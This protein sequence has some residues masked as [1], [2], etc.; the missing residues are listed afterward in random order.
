MRQGTP[1]LPRPSF[2][3]VYYRCIS[4]LLKRIAYTITPN[5]AVIRLLGV[6][7]NP[8]NGFPARPLGVG[9]HH[10]KPATLSVPD[11]DGRLGAGELQ[12]APVQVEGFGL[13]KR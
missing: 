1:I 11:R 6:V 3:N 12:I 10:A 5:T 7:Q 8:A 13:A 2:R 9:R 4:G